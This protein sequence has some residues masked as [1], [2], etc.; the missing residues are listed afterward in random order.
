MPDGLTAVG[1]GDP[2]FAAVYTNC[3]TVFGFVDDGAQN[4]QLRRYDILG[5]YES[6]NDC[7]K[8]YA[9]LARQKPGSNLYDALV[10][11]YKWKVT[12]P[13]AAFPANS[14]Y[15][16]SVDIEP[17]LKPNPAIRLDS[18]GKSFLADKKEEEDLWESISLKPLRFG[19]S[20]TCLGENQ[21]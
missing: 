21:F 8:L 18:S 16:A 6:T 2:L 9:S 15:Y 13:P 1:Y 10:S 12:N 7:L 14:V 20:R 17:Q 3:S 5:W 4:D 19:W 11:E